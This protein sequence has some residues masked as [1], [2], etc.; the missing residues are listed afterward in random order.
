MSMMLGGHEIVQ[1]IFKST[2]TYD[3]LQKAIQFFEFM[4]FHTKKRHPEKA[5]E[6]LPFLNTLKNED[7]GY[8]SGEVPEW[9]HYYIGGS[10]EA[11]IVR[12]PIDIISRSTKLKD[13]YVCACIRHTIIAEAVQF[14]DRTEMEEDLSFGDDDEELSDDDIIETDLYDE[15]EEM[16][17]NLDSEG[18][19]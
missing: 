16:D 1:D 7:K 11:I 4:Y 9:R 10:D 12:E 2:D 15:L 8:P 18:E 13:R 5:L 6:L 17:K 3:M 14:L 19:I